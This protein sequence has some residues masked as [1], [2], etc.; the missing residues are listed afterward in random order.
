MLLEFYH[1][2]AMGSYLP[3]VFAPKIGQNWYLKFIKLRFASKNM[4]AGWQG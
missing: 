3:M 1:I 2:V 4:C